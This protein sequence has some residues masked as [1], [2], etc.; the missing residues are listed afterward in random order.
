MQDRTLLKAPFPVVC[1]P[2][3]RRSQWVPPP[4]LNWT[5]CVLLLPGCLLSPVL[6]AFIVRQAKNSW[7]ALGWKKKKKKKKPTHT[8]GVQ[9]PCW[10][11]LVRSGTENSSSLLFF[12]TLALSIFSRSCTHLL[13]NTWSDGR[14]FPP[15]LPKYYNYLSAMKGSF[16]NKIFSFFLYNL[17][18][19][20]GAAL[21]KRDLC[22]FN[23]SALLQP[24]TPLPR[25]A[26]FPWNFPLWCGMAFGGIWKW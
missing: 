14:N 12:H 23:I 8:L 10:R 18:N 20:C 16:E 5:W 26:S 22:V 17:S 6:F 15:Q 3:C 1:G 7:Q 21:W 11:V 25:C 4:D 19:D 2:G 24:D 9:K 13:T